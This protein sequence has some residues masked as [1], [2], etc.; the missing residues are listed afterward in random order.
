VLLLRQLAQALDYAHERGVIH[1]DLKPANAFVRANDHVT[2]VDF[3]IAR[4]A[5]ASRVTMSYGLGTPA[6]M[7]PERFDED[8][9]RPGADAHTLGVDADLYALGV[10]TYELIA[11]EQPFRGKTREAIIFERLDG[12]PEPIGSSRSGVPEDVEVVVL[13]QLSRDP[14]ERLPAARFATALADGVRIERLLADASAAIAQGR[15][16]DAQRLLTDADATGLRPRAVE[17][18]R[19]GIAARTAIPARRANALDLLARGDWR[20][21][22]EEIRWLEQQGAPSLQPLVERAN[23]LHWAELGRLHVERGDVAGDRPGDGPFPSGPFPGHATGVQPPPWQSQPIG[24]QQPTPPAWQPDP[25]ASNRQQAVRRDRSARGPAT[26]LVVLGIALAVAAISATAVLLLFELPV[27]EV[28]VTRQTLGLREDLELVV[29][30]AASAPDLARRV[31]PGTAMQQRIEVSGSLPASG[32]RRLGLERARGVILF[33][34]Q[35]ALPVTIPGGTALVSGNNVRFVTDRDVTVPPRSLGTTRV[36]ITAAEAG[37]A[38]NVGARTIGRF[39][40]R[41]FGNLVPRNDAPTTGGTDQIERVVTADDRA[42][43]QEQLES[44]A[45]EQALAELQARA[46]PD[47]TVIAESVTLTL[48]DSTFEPAV[49]A[50]A[51]RVTGR[52]VVVANAVAVANGALIALVQQALLAQQTDPDFDLPE[53]RVSVGPLAVLGHEQDRVRMQAAVTGTALRRI[54]VDDLARRLRW[55]P[56][57]EART[58]LSRTDGLIGEP[59]IE[60]WPDWPFGAHR[61]LVTLQPED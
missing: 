46:G 22:L 37:S 45:R 58:V 5:D 54:D 59:R 20:A 43:L 9:A 51:D 16:E 3:G 15:F 19:K 17:T 26:G 30:P 60:L 49:D 31:L 23:A 24:Y 13:R 47:S 38:G 25:Y 2:L 1:R 57:A 50:T 10:V 55:K 61:V 21:A 56:V 48:E 29:D 39:E 8:L 27:L 44:R 42:R 36:G 53:S 28:T 34:S 11:G 14:C 41:A 6:Y 4:A 7:A 40:T 32:S 33:V 52:Y 35:N 18:L 12:E